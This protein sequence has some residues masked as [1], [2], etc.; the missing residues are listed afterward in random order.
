METF[1]FISL[2]ITFILI[3]LLV[4]HFKQRILAV[5][6]KG[7]T[8]FEIINNLIMETSTLKQYVRS[9]P[10]F[11]NRGGPMQPPQN[12]TM[13]SPQHTVFQMHQPMSQDPVEEEDEDEEENDQDDD[14]DEE[15]NDQ[16]DD[17]D[18]DDQDDDEDDQYEHEAGEEDEDEAE[19]E[20]VNP[21]KIIVSDDEY[22]SNI[23]VEVKEM[24]E[25]ISNQDQ[26]L[27]NMSME[28]QEEDIE[29]LIEDEEDM[30][31]EEEEIE[32]VVKQEEERL[33]TPSLN[34]E[35]ASKKTVD[36]GIVPDYR[37]MSM[38]ELKAAVLAKS[39]TQD[40]SKLKKNQL[41]QLLGV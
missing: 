37:K 32:S 7:D 29:P 38:P 22:V 9:L 10:M 41:L 23:E 21:T 2:G 27:G 4:Y 13:E 33:P 34:H 15:E 26:D 39:L 20:E 3:L 17:E 16:D 5:E 18:E 35:D 36:L 30:E 28:L 8:L 14:E 24:S 25:F 40:V 31:Q 19:A 11:F 1:F 12:T 6:Q